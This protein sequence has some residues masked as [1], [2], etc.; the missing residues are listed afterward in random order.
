MD[1]TIFCNYPT[2]FYY[3]Y[4]KSKLS[5]L[6]GSYIFLTGNTGVDF[7][8]VLGFDDLLSDLRVREQPKN[9]S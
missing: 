3:G 9:K 6:Y 1:T 5:L 2:T 8:P 7:F 4:L